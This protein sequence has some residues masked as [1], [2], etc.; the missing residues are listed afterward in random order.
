MVLAVDEIREGGKVE[1]NDG[2][3]GGKGVIGVRKAEGSGVV[4][5]PK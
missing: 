5:L 2:L 3:E 1:I 4:V